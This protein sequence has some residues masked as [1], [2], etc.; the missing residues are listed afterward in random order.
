AVLAVRAELAEEQLARA[1]IENEEARLGR[2]QRIVDDR[3]QILLGDQ[4]LIRRAA[5]CVERELQ[6]FGAE[7]GRL[8]EQHLD[9]R[10]GLSRMGGYDGSDE[11]NDTDELLHWTNATI[12][13]SSAI[14]LPRR[15]IP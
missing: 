9:Q 13:K 12:N 14:L 10:S 11:K 5:L 7:A 1:E 3:Q 2:W 4:S 6:H 15:E 8:L